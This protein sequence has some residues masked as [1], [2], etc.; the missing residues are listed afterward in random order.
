MAEEEVRPI[1]GHT[2]QFDNIKFEIVEVN[3]TRDYRKREILM[4]SYRIREGNYVSPVA[5]L[6]LSP[7][8]SLQ[9]EVRRVIETYKKFKRVLTR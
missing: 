9:E 5:H 2:Y 4:I 3:R 1:A 8:Q 6:F 7:D